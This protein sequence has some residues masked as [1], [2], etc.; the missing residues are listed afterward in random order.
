MITDERPG[1]AERYSSATESSNL[2]VSEKSSDADF[3][4]AAGMLGDTLGRLL[5]RLHTEF[6]LVRGQVSADKAL[7]PTDR[8]LVLMNLKTLRETRLAL[9]NFAVMTAT[10]RKFTMNDD[11]VNK[12]AGRALDVHLDPL[13]H[14][15]QGRGFNGGSHR[16]EKQELCRPCR[17]A[18]HRRDGLGKDSEERQFASHLLAELARVVDGA[19]RE[20]GQNKGQKVRRMKDLITDAERNV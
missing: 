1:I 13:C 9:G 2:R 8:L 7:S 17:G 6:D 4:I 5:L 3:L 15:C 11:A 18:G 12:I 16:G 14:H 10:R 20:L 19:E